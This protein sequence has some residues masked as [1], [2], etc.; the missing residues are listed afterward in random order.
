M[1]ALF[2]DEGKRLDGIPWND[3]PRPQMRRADWL[4]LNGSWVFSVG[5]LRAEI[6]VPFC[7]ESLLSGLAW[8]MD[9]GGEMTYRRAFTL[10]EGW[11]GKRVL[12]HFGAVSRIAVV[13]LNG[14]AVA[15]HEN[16]Y[17]PFSAEI[18]EHLRPGENEL[19]VL[20]IND[21]SHRHPWGKQ[22][23]RRGGMWYTPVSGIWQTV[24]LEAVPETY[25]RALSIR[26][27]ADWADITAEGITT[28]TVLLEGREYPMENGHV[29]IPVARPHLWSPEDPCLYSFAVV[30]GEDRVESYFALRTLS[31]EA[32]DGIPRLCLNGRPYFFHGLLDQGY[33]SDGLYTPAAPEC[34]ERDILAMKALGFNTLRKHI[35]IE[36]E[37]F[38]Y[39]C[40]RLG[41]IVF[42]DMVNCGDVRY[43][44]DTVLPTLGFQKR[45]DHRMNRDRETRENFLEAMEETVIRLGNH[46]SIC[47]WTIFNEGWGQF[48]ADDACR[49]L[50]ALDDSRFI[51][52]TSGWFH[53]RES[54][55]DSLHIYFRR[56]H[57][58][59]NKDRPQLLSE[60]GGYVYKIP[61][62]SFNLKKTYGYRQCPD[63]ETF[64]RD[65][66]A[67][68]EEQ[69]LPLIR[70]GLCGAI[71]TQVS[72]V[73]DE[74]NGLLTFDRK[75]GKITPEEF[76]EL[77]AR[78]RES[79]RPAEN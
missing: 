67:L 15:L 14:A 60:F 55:V 71:Y 52:S 33:W 30:S 54:D 3:Y 70:Q 56:L 26:T 16:S 19:E 76:A 49:R 74:T 29:R 65:L 77:S 4:C 48:R 58:G 66:R 7:P 28:G 42:Q 20:A 27:G 39:D 45:P 13:R 5:E 36:P 51:D 10:P 1:E 25:I 72:D 37:R 53:Q 79:I 31:V 44:R 38:Y 61:E 11:A 6:E 9:Y 24:W 35:K 50:R 63:R 64:V 75:A 40:D 47:L 17:L 41:M 78:L 43:W 34:Y 23:A 22:R 2:T 73:E 46:P 57:L 18:T 12:L 21:L 69:V 32:V 68:Y 8:T 62:H 59:K